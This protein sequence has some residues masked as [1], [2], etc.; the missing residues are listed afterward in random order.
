MSKI[1]CTVEFTSDYNDAGYE[2]DSVVV[3]CS[4]CGYET[5]SWG[6]GARSINRCLVLLNGECPHAENN[7]YVVD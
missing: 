7:L 3:T 5:L 2:V 4:K 1:K 6:Q